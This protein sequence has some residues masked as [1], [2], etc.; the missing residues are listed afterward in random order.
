MRGILTA[1]MIGMSLM[2]GTLSGNVCAQS[3]KELSR[4]ELP[5]WKM[6]YVIIED[7]ERNMIINVFDGDELIISDIDHDNI[8]VSADVIDI[9]K[10]G[11]SELLLTRHS[12]GNCCPPV[13]SIYFLNFNGRVNFYKFEQWDAWGG[14]DDAKFIYAGQETRISM[15]HVPAGVGYNKLEK[16]RTT[17]TYDGQNVEFLNKTAVKKITAIKEIHSSDFDNLKQTDFQSIVYDLN[18]DG[19]NEIIECSYWERWGVL[20]SC[21]IQDNQGIKILLEDTSS[22]HPKRIGILDEHFN[23]W[24]VLVADFDQKLIYDRAKRRYVLRK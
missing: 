8:R 1:L 17:Y 13:L 16:Y 6:R 21:Q 12:I 18:R 11:I 20:S 23:G 2:I 7:D 22:F 10:D 24:H 15:E 19:K 14:W 4:H 9:N 5:S 3:V